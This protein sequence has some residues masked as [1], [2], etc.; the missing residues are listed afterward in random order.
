M[1]KLYDKIYPLEPDNIDT[2]VFNKA[3]SLSWV[4][5]QIFIK[6]DYIFDNMIPDILN[7]FD[8]INIAKTPYKKL[9]YIQKII[10]DIGNLI[11]FNEGE[12]KE[13]IGDDEIGPV[14]TYFFIKAHPLRIYTDL[15]FIKIFLKNLASHNKSISDFESRYKYLID[16]KAEDFN[17]TQDEYQRKCDESMNNNNS[18]KFGE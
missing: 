14:L 1:N 17:L 2:K 3:I 8:Q 6:N 5:P 18:H 7:E 11:K 12:G 13:E 15:E 4:E 9:N 16:C 10:N